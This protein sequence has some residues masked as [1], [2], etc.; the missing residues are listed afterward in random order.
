L[1]ALRAAG[2]SGAIA[3]DRLAKGLSSQE[4]DHPFFPALR[5]IAGGTSELA[6]FAREFE[7]GL[8]DKLAEERATRAAPALGNEGPRKPPP[9]G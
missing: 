5:K 2:P 1:G 7:T 9:G 3:M 4:S 6:A 8:S